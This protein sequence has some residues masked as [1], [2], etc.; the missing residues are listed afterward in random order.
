MKLLV[1][2]L[3]YCKTDNIWKVNDEKLESALHDYTNLKLK[4]I[5]DELPR[6]EHCSICNDLFYLEE[7]TKCDKCGEMICCNCFDDNITYNH[8]HNECLCNECK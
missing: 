6:T 1:G 5:I 4:I 2:N 3:K 8:V 7:L